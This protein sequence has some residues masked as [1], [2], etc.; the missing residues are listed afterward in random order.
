MY[1]MRCRSF[2]SR[3]VFRCTFQSTR[4]CTCIRSTCSRRSR[5]IDRSICSMPSCLPVVHTLVATNVSPCCGRIASRSP[6]TS[7]ALPYMGEE[8]ITRPP[9][10]NNSSSTLPRWPWAAASRPTS[11]PSHVPHPM[12]GKGCDV[13]GTRRVCTH[14]EY[15][16]PMALSPQQVLAH[17]DSNTYW[18]EPFGLTLQEAY[19]HQL[20]VRELRLAGGEKPLGFKI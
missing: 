15:S 19:E 12:T 11:K 6:T 3:S 4:L 1:E 8:S 17:L 14:R 16:A 13:E 7:S 10:P 2:Q 5:A 18:P 9:A 20:A